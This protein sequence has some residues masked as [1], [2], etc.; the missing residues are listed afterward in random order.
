[1]KK[2]FFL[3]LFF[4]LSTQKTLRAQQECGTKAYTGNDT[5]IINRLAEQERKTQEWINTSPESRAKYYK[6][7]YPAIPG[8]TPTGDYFKDAAA[9][10]E[11][12]KRFYETDPVGY[13]KWNDALTA[14]NPPPILT[15]EE[16]KRVEGKI[17]NRK[18]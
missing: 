14:N 3:S 11:A 18:Q 6:I 9:Y 17:K 15:K 16:Q 1:M 4:S 10:T 2:I 8:F 13:K 7:Q 12:K 5:A